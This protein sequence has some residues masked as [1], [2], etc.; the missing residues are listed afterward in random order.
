[1]LRHNIDGLD[2][3]GERRV[4]VQSAEVEDQEDEA[5]FPTIVGERE[6]GKTIS[7][8]ISIKIWDRRQMHTH[9]NIYP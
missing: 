2:G 9:T 5:V 3:C 4:R 8:H 7:Y 6:L 1:V